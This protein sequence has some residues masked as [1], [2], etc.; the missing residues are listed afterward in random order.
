[1]KQEPHL[2]T[3]AKKPWSNYNRIHPSV[4]LS[5]GNHGK[6]WKSCKLPHFVEQPGDVNTHI[7]YQNHYYRRYQPVEP[8]G[9]RL[10]SPPA[11]FAILVAS[12]N[13]LECWPQN[14]R[15]MGYGW[16]WDK[17]LYLGVQ[18]KAL[19]VDTQPGTFKRMISQRF[20]RL[21]QWSFPLPPNCNPKYEGYVGWNI[22]KA[23]NP[24]EQY[25][26]IAVWYKMEEAG[27]LPPCGFLW[28]SQNISGILKSSLK[29]LQCWPTSVAVDRLVWCWWYHLVI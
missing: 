15:N 26:T 27:S 13:M 23:T 4:D 2:A 17:I 8:D 1:M 22:G 10:R 16:V 6:I 21:S 12:W 20:W 5:D 3:S 7:P 14:L 28:I 9:A 25:R 11:A 29:S 19:Q 24:L 18:K